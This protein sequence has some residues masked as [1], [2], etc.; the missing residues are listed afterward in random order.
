[1]PFTLFRGLLVAS[2]IG[3]GQLAASGDDPLSLLKKGNKRFVENKTVFGD[4][5]EDQRLELAK[6]QSPFATLVVCSDS[7]LSPELILDQHLGKLFV[8]R[9]AGNVVDQFALATIEYGVAV[10]GTPLIVVM[11][12]Q[13][14]G[15]VKEAFKLGD[16]EYSANIASLLTEISPAVKS[17]KGEALLSD[18]EKLSLAIQ[19]NVENTHRQMIL[20]SPIIREHVSSGKV[21]I[22]DSIFYIDSGKVEWGPFTDK[23][24][25][26]WKK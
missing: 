17:V 10:L 7:R 9:L 20:R 12:H 15:A 26:F 25:T 11:G 8:I 24:K 22:V 6:G 3:F 23:P 5:S 4:V 21:K 19:Y 1:M 14:C 13:N 16:K 2:I 18:D